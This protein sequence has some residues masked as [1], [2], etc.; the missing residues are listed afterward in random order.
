MFENGG[1]IAQFVHYPDFY[2]TEGSQSEALVSTIDIAPTILAF[3]D[4]ERPYEL[5]GQSWRLAIKPDVVGLN[6]QR[7]KNFFEKE[8]CLLFEYQRDRAVRCGC[9]KIMRLAGAREY[10]GDDE[11]D[12]EFPGGTGANGLVPTLAPT[13]LDNIERKSVTLTLG[14]EYEF[15]EED[16]TA[17]DT[18]TFLFDLCDE[19]GGTF[20]GNYITGADNVAINPEVTDLFSAG[21]NETFIQGGQLRNVLLCFLEQTNASTEPTFRPSCG[22]SY[23]SPVCQSNNDCRFDSLG[24]V[25]C[26]P[27]GVC[28]T[29]E[30]SNN[31]GESNDGGEIGSEGGQSSQATVTFLIVSGVVVLVLA[32]LCWVCRKKS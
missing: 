17:E 7:V 2:G 18:A 16:V 8:R 11:N 15:F 29:I 27:A 31:I 19:T 22:A 1:R 32:A 14:I 24:R 30:T 28:R 6:R 13:S 20:A 5:D 21:D 23:Y 12:E 3:A 26:S 10:F 9:A 4:I 25:D